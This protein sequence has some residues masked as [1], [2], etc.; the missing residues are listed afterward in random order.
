MACI[1]KLPGKGKGAVSFTTQELSVIQQSNNTQQ[2]MQAMR[3]KWA[4]GLHH[5]WHNYGYGRPAMFDFEL[6]GNGDLGSFKPAV[7]M[8][9]CNFVPDEFSQNINTHK[10]WDILN[11]ARPVAFKRINVMYDVIRQLYDRGVM[12]RV[13]LLIPTDASVDFQNFLEVYMKKF[14]FDERRLFNLIS[15]THDY[16]FTYDTSTIAFL[17]HSSKIFLHCAD[18]ERRCRTVANAMAAGLPTVCSK[19]PASIIPTPRYKEPYLYLVNNDNEYT[20]CIIKA[21]KEYKGPND[22]VDDFVPTHTVKK[23]A[24]HLA[25]IC[26][27]DEP[28]LING[29]NLDIR[30]G[31]HHGISIGP[32]KVNYTVDEFIDKLNDIV[33]VTSVF[34]SED[35][36]RIL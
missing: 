28:N 10:H 33:K 5:N 34:W 29:R 2:K 23:I 3:V 17:Y 25:P 6:A 4:S 9:A 36:E 16:P 20:K 32:N 19:D 26:G 1:L 12:A 7:P 14:N 30:L 11:V 35:P 18:Q 31:R 24:K 22:P 8:D 21:L 13:L 15:P 27:A